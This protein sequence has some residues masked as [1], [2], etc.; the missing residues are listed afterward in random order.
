MRD[1]NMPATYG[2]LVLL[3]LIFLYEGGLAGQ[4]SLTRLVQLG[5]QVNGYVLLDGQW[6]RIFTAMFLHFGWIHILLNG[7][8][9]Y[10]MG[11]LVEPALGTRNYLFVYVLAGILGGLLS[12]ALYP[13]NVVMVGASGAIFGLLGATAVI[14]LHS[15]GQTRSYLMRW[16]VSILVLNLGFDFLQPG[17]GV[18]DHVGGLVGGFLAAYVVYG[19]ARGRTTITYAAGA[20]YVVLAAFLITYAQRLVG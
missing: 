13:L 9:L 1:R 11:Q 5:A 3:A 17:I 8:S 16:L 19:A 7:W 4:P 20:A 10:V 6:W 12:L 2:L 15:G 18:W 14:A